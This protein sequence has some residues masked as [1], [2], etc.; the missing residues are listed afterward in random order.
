MIE[1]VLKSVREAEEKAEEIRLSAEDESNKI[2][3]GAD[4]KAAEI[5]ESAK[6]FVSAERERI[7]SEA[8]KTSQRE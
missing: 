2:R 6:Q 8:E 7:L 4:K 5:T 3:L 1:D